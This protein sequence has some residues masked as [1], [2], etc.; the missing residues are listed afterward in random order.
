MTY[1]VKIGTYCQTGEKVQCELTL[2]AVSFDAAR[3]EAEKRFRQAVA[4]L[5]A[6]NCFSIDTAKIELLADAP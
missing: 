6:S 4:N 3:T 2:A 5:A 1:K